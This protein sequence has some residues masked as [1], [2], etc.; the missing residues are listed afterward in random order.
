[1][2][3]FLPA[4]T[5]EFPDQHVTDCVPS[6]ALMAVNKAT[7][8]SRP[9]GV[10]EREA[11]QGA[12]GTQDQ[13][14]TNEQAAA[15]IRARY[16]LSLPLVNGWPAMALALTDPRKGLAII[17]SYQQ[18]PAVIR[19]HGLQPSFN[20]LH[21]IYAQADDDGLVAIGDPLGTSFVRGRFLAELR[22]Y[23]ESTRYAALVATEL[24]TIVGWRAYVGPGTFTAW[25]VMRWTHLAYDPKSTTFA[26]RS[27]ARVQH[28]AA[29]YWLFLDG[30]FPGRY[31]IA[32]RSQPFEVY[33]V[34]SDGHLSKVSAAT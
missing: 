5:S 31:A 1:M 24:A 4:F 32:G 18:L 7:H 3:P 17:G 15:G 34:W 25:R 14:A 11:L 10:A 19:G 28:G 6:A 29:G 20:G 2:T 33:A 13:G 26:R 8:N 16:G 12:M 23:A 9:A 30:A 21:D 22:A 27:W